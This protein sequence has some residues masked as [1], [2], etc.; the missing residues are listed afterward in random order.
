MVAVTAALH[1]GAGDVVML[2]YEPAALHCALLGAR[3]SGARLAA[4]EGDLGASCLLPRDGGALRERSAAGGGEIRAEVL[5]WTEL[6]AG[7]F[8]DRLI[9]TVLLLLGVSAD[10]GGDARAAEERACLV[11]DRAARTQ[12]ARFAAAMAAA[13]ARIRDQRYA[14]PLPAPHRVRNATVLTRSKPS[15]PDSKWPAEPPSGS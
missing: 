5:D 6:N 4:A 2:D 15:P 13:G 11:G 14:P 9:E 8:F 10:G 12:R 7:F 1:G 3:A